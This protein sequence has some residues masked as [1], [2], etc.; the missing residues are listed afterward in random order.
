VNINSAQSNVE[1][2]KMRYNDA[3][4]ELDRQKQLNNKELDIQQA[5]SNFENAVV[6][7]KRQE[8]LHEE[9]VI[10]DQDLENFK[11]D[12]A[13]KESIFEN[14]K[15]NASNDLLQ[16]ANELDIRGQEYEAARNNLQ[17][18]REGVTQN[19]KQIS[20]IIYSTMSGMVLDLP[21]E[22]GSS[23]IE[24]NNFNE[25]TSVASI[26][27]MSTLIFEGM[28]DESD[29]GKLKEGM[30][31]TIVVG[32]IDDKQFKGVLEFI[33]PK[34]IEEEG[35]IK[36]E[37]KAAIEQTEDE[38]AFLR[39]GYSANADIIIE[40]RVKVV[41][42]NERD[43]IIEGD[44]TFVEIVTGDQVFEKS[45][46]QTGLSDGIYIEMVEGIDTSTQIKMRTDPGL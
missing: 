9:G 16:L 30:E 39:A 41:C 13:L 22:E 43:I 15:I 3:K 45:K 19:S 10:S 32:A 25:G 7:L 46:V 44:S 35:S 28:V 21:V 33:S 23:V 36:F 37:I 29:V 6:V 11:L 14:T 18:L 38:D 26:A 20:N 27:D 42:I 4:R 24:R 17:L 2:T 34:G 31:L 8:S 5:K 1:L 40:K 12:K